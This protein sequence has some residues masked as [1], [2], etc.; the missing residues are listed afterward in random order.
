MNSILRNENGKKVEKKKHDFAD[1]RIMDIKMM[2]NT[3]IILFSDGYCH[4]LQLSANIL[5]GNFANVKLV[6]NVTKI[7]I[8]ENHC[9]LR[10]A[11]IGTAIGT[12]DSGGFFKIWNFGYG[13]SYSQTDPCELKE[14]STLRID[15]AGLNALLALDLT[16]IFAG[17]DRQWVFY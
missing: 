9:P 16:T 15:N 4:M 17:G 8:S 7:C 13:N 1:S 5:T 10:M 6:H 3:V 14:F 12:V 2:S 11:K